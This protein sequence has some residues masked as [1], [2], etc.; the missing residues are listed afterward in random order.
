MSIEKI[1]INDILAECQE[2]SSLWGIFCGINTLF[3]EQSQNNNLVI[4]KE[5][6]AWMYETGKITFYSAYKDNKKNV[7]HKD[8]IYQNINWSLNCKHMYKSFV[9]LTDIGDKFYNDF[10]RNYTTSLKKDGLIRKGIKYNLALNVLKKHE[11]SGY[12][13]WVSSLVNLLGIP[14]VSICNNLIE[15]TNLCGSRRCIID[16]N[17]NTITDLYIPDNFY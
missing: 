9:V 13:F 8:L 1:V 14:S 11:E 15:H 17:T 6:T 16:T 4:A 5:V 10:M 7:L 12:L 3:P 2:E